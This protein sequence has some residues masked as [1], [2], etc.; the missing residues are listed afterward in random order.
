MLCPRR[1]GFTPGV[2]FSPS[3]ITVS[4]GSV[5]VMRSTPLTGERPIGEPDNAD[6]FICQF[7]GAGDDADVPVL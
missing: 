4:S 3:T 7:A 6:V 5:F 2:M 1:C